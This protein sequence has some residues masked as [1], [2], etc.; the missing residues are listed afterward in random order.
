MSRE[1]HLAAFPFLT[2]FISQARMHPWPSHAAYGYPVVCFTIFRARYLDMGMIA[3]SKESWGLPQGSSRNLP[4]SAGDMVS[5][6]GRRAKI[7][8]AAEQISPCATIIEP[9]FL[10]QGAAATEPAHHNYRGCMSQVESL[11]TTMEDP[12][13]HN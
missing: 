2:P 13:C 11:C 5:I 1:G 7:P 6:L 8:H 10:G 3:A 12:T 9:V 4:C